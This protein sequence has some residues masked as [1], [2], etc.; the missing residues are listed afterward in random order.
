MNT[1]L[2]IDLGT[3]GLKVSLLTEDGRLLGS[4][5]REYPIHTPRPG[6]AE[7]DPEA[8][9]KGLIEGCHE[10]RQRYPAPFGAVLGVGICGQ[11]H[12]QVYLDGQDQVLRPA[13]TWMDQR[14][15]GIVDGLNAD[16]DVKALIFRET[17]NLATTT[18][19]A[20]QVKWV[21]QNEPEVWRQ[22]ARVL[23][24]K[25]FL[26]YRLTGRLVT[27]YAEASGI[28][29]GLNADPVVKALIFRAT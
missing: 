8:W 5:Y 23:V 2:G 3:T 6:Y 9:W 28:V 26:K 17:K 19:T 22:V 11:M 12:T 20:P 24:A 1:L 13:I 25:D 21:Q 14:A 18:Y 15:S 4:A 7:Q 27:D 10:L 29:D 16:P